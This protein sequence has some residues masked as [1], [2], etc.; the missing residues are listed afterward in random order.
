M[1]MAAG[2]GAET[3]ENA[4]PGRPVASLILV[5]IAEGSRVWGYSRFVLGRFGVGSVPGLRFA[6]VLGSGQDGGFGLRPS[7][8]RQGLFCVFEDDDSAAAFLTQHPLVKCYQDH[9]REFFSVRLH[10]YACRGSWGGVSLPPITSTPT[11]GPIAAL[12]RA[13]IKPAQATAFWRKA[14]PAQAD[15]EHAEGCLLAA[16]LGEAPL[17]RQATFSV[18]CDVG[19]MD[20]YAR[21]GAHL[22]AIKAAHRHGFFSESMFARFV[23]VDMQGTY[24]NKAYG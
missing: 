19:D 20:R 12:T 4:P 14:P 18:W 15:L 21:T 9:A 16:G 6:R 10:S 24:K 8:T 11:Q 5:D 13:S 3:L 22:E 1:G 23:P 2:A 7:A 17:L